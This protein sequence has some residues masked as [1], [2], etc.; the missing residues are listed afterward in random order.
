METNRFYVPV[1]KSKLGEFMALEKLDTPFKD[2]IVPLFEVTPMEWDFQ[3]RSKPRTMQEH[4]DRFCNKIEKRWQ[5]QRCFIDTSLLKTDQADNAFEIE[6]IFEKLDENSLAIPCINVFGSD[7]FI[8]ALVKVLKARK[9]VAAVRCTIEDVTDPDFNNKLDA[10]LTKAE[11]N[12]KACHIIFDLKDA[13]FSRIDEFANTISAVIEFF[14]HLKEWASFTVAGSA[15]AASSS[16]KPPSAKIARNDWK[17]YQSLIEIIFAKDYYRPINFGDYSIV[18][19]GYFEFDPTKM[20]SSANI[21][22]THDDFWYVVKGT[23]LKK[24]EDF[25][26]YL[27]QATVIYESKYYAGEDYSEGDAYIA[28]CVR[29]EVSTGN[30]TTWNWVGNNHHFTKVIDGLFSIRPEPS[31]NE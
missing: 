6:Y 26:Q 7:S 28:K 17:V 2:H 13:D 19:P 22:Y 27:N 12:P 30:P 11:L 1:L 5:E 24:K 4:L 9:K 31:D 25:K 21:R 18:A 14:P 29:K 16:I 8:E 23:A 3:T 10:I 15:F 20:S